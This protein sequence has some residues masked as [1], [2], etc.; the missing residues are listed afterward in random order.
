M[1]TPPPPPPAEFEDLQPPDDDD[2]GSSD[3]DEETND[4][5]DVFNS[6]S[7]DWLHAQ[8]THHVSLAA[9]KSFWQ[10]AM[11]YIP[12]M[13]ELKAQERNTRKIP[14]FLQVR[15]NIYEEA[16][17]VVTMNF[18]FLN[19]NDGSITHARVN[20]TPLNMYQRDPRYKKLYEEAHIEV[21]YY[22]SVN[23]SSLINIYYL[24]IKVS[25]LIN[26]YYILYIK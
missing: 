19:K 11:K 6:L 13:M 5:K 23:V 22:I 25:S 16:A 2:P 21:I 24:S 26:I 9:A 8:L 1:A 12:E 7:R 10:T 20:H 15:K 17:P 18:A 4:Y 3:I 14:Q